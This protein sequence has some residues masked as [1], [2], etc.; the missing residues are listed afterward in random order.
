MPNAVIEAFHLLLCR[1]VHT[2]QVPCV[3]AYNAPCLLQESRVR[4]LGSSRNGGASLLTSISTSHRDRT[5]SNQPR[6]SSAAHSS[7]ISLSTGGLRANPPG[8]VLHPS[9]DPPVSVPAQAGTPVVAGDSISS[10]IDSAAHENSVV[11]RQASHSQGFASALSPAAQNQGFRGSAQ[12]PQS[13]QASAKRP[14]SGS[15]S[16]APRRSQSAAVP[17]AVEPPA[18]TPTPQPPFWTGCMQQLPLAAPHQPNER[19]SANT[20]A[21][22]TWQHP[23]TGKSA[24]QQPTGQKGGRQR[25]QS[26]SPGHAAGAASSQASAR[27]MDQ[28]GLASRPSPALRAV[29]EDTGTALQHSKGPFPQAALPEGRAGSL[30]AWRGMYTQASTSQVAAGDEAGQGSRS[31]ACDASAHRPAGAAQPHRVAISSSASRP[32]S[33]QDQGVQQQQSEA[34]GASHTSG[35]P[36]AEKQGSGHWQRHPASGSM[37][38]CKLAG[39]AG[40]GTMAEEEGREPGA[41]LDLTE[42]ER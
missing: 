23:K 9:R 39:P 19:I 11:Q 29:L 14:L 2:S 40:K 35:S 32:H 13:A 22:D 34:Q 31:G 18:V 6:P 38:A 25:P 36:A 28:T 21:H 15:S 5:N 3:H 10:A 42:A 7:R 33:T 27:G 24:V 16:K 4:S 17:R 26:A 12:R 30:R 41:A 1:A 37:Q 8:S 20:Y